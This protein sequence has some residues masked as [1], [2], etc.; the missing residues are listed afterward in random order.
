M[1]SQD[2]LTLQ[3]WFDQCRTG[4]HEMTPQGAE[5]FSR[6]IGGCFAQA[7]A[8]EKTPLDPRTVEPSLNDLPDTT[9]A[10]LI[11][12]SSA[13]ASAANVVMLHA[14]RPLWSGDAPRGGSAA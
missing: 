1:L 6:A 5:A 10:D 9:I 8:M 14:D 3:I 11:R 12:M 7:V 4:Q 13:M 2:L